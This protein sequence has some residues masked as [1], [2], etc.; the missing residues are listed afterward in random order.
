M[1]QESNIESLITA[2]GFADSVVYIEGDRCSVVVQAEDLQQQESVQIMQIVLS[3]SAVTA[4]K[5]QI[6]AAKA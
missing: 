3:Q 5:V 4:D 6:M 2:K 1:L